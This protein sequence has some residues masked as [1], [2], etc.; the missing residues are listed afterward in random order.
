MAGNLLFMISSITVLFKL[1]SKL[2]CENFDKENIIVTA[3][4]ILAE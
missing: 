3:C 2:F 1:A 4:R